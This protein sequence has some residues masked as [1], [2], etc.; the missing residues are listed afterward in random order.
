VISLD[1]LLLVA[2]SLR[3]KLWSLTGANLW[4]RAQQNAGADSPLQTSGLVRVVCQYFTNPSCLA[5]AGNPG[6]D[7]TSRMLGL[8]KIDGPGYSLVVAIRAAI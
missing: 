3:V 8:H 7:R 5:S 6:S 1:Q 4:S 2:R